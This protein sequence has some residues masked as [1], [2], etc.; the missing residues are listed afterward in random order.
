MSEAD[1]TPH[2]TQVAIARRPE[3]LD[4]SAEAG[5]YNLQNSSAIVQTRP[6]TPF[7]SSR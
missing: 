4:V 6:A 2:S 3:Q 1:V 7:G 5:A